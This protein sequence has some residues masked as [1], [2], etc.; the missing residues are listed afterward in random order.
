MKGSP[1]MLLNKAEYCKFE[2]L[3]RS[4]PGDTPTFYA[5][6]FTQTILMSFGSDK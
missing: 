4:C 6:L 2:G 3:T 5:I 1:A